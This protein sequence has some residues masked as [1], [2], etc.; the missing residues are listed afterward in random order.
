MRYI[1]PYNKEWYNSL[2]TLNNPIFFKRLLKSNVLTLLGFATN[3]D[4][5]G[6]KSKILT[7]LNGGFDG[8]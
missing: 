1:K 2:Y 7:S 6:N 3:L 8:G 5:D 4:L